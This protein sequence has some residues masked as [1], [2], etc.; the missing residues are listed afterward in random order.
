M[1]LSLLVKSFGSTLL[2][3]GAG[4]TGMS[5]KGGEKQP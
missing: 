3:R 2:P 4:L 5:V 1:R